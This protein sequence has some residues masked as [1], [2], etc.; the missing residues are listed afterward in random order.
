MSEGMRNHQPVPE[1]VRTQEDAARAAARWMRYW[2]YDD[3]VVAAGTDTR[4]DVAATRAMAQVRFLSTAVGQPALQQLVGAQRGVGEQRL[5]FFTGACYT[6]QALTYAE[7]MGIGLFTFDMTGGRM[8]P[9]SNPARAVMDAAR[10]RDLAASGAPSASGPATTSPLVTGQPRQSLPT[11]KSAGCLAVL[12]FIAATCL[13]IGVL[14][15]AYR[16]EGITVLTALVALAGA[17]AYVIGLLTLVIAV[18]AARRQGRRG[19]P[20]AAVL[21]GSAPGVVV[22]LSTGV[23]IDDA[24]GTAAGF[25]QAIIMT[26]PLVALLAVAVRPLDVRR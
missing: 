10:A 7:D 15:A 9:H 1:Q 4:I 12:M 3:A 26:I 17:V 16:P 21:L 24:R 2:G 23:Y 25:L 8:S 14:A 19:A 6:R 13:Q 11:P 18:V 5:L 22:W 20:A